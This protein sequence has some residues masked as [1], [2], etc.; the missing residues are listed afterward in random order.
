MRAWAKGLLCAEAAV[1]LLIGH[2]WWLCRKDFASVAV[3]PGRNV[4]TGTA[5]AGIDWQAADRALESGALPCSS[6]EGQVL[7]IAAS[8]AAGIP[9]DLREAVTGLDEGNAVL[10]ATAVLHAAGHRHPGAS[11]R[12]DW[13]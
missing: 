12:G 8:I 13:R 5:V 10:A 7:R 4:F 1:E 6:G 11:A 2:R 9:V 3:K